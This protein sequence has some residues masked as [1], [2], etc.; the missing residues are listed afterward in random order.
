[1]TD[2][3]ATVNTD[4][5]ADT[6]AT[7]H[8]DLLAGTVSGPEAAR[9]LG[10]LLD[11]LQ[12]LLAEAGLLLPELSSVTPVEVAAADDPTPIFDGVLAEMPGTAKP[13]AVTKTLEKPAERE[14]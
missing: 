6:I 8:T 2:D 11:A 4:K 3:E 10:H 13:E 7:L 5:P 12:E 14:T 9:R 1:M